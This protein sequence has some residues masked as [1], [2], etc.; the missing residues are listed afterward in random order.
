MSSQV[1]RTIIGI[2]VSKDKLD[3]YL[4][5]I[6]KHEVIVNDKKNIRHFF[7]EIEKQYQVDKVI[8]ERTGGYEANCVAIAKAEN[9]PLHIAHPNQVYHFAKSKR[10]LAKT[11]KIDA[12]IL[13]CFGEQAEIKPTQMVSEKEEELKRLVRRKQ[14]L[15]DL[16]TQEKLRL[17]GPQAVGEMGRSIKRI[18][19]QLEQEIKLLQ[20]KLNACVED[21][22]DTREKVKRLK[23][24][25]GIGEITAV[26]LA[27]TM[28]ELGK[29]GPGGHCEFIWFSPYKS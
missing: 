16:L 14:Q 8:V 5:P 12:K 26:T 21:C 19:K 9:L 3:I 7:R 27:V 4:N 1:N 6:G 2:D 13:S 10:L 17:A 18:V 20:D 22:E 28:P 11:D 29:V 23:T 15:T 24:F 25:K